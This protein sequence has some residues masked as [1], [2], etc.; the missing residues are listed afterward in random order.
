MKDTGKRGHRSKSSTLKNTFFLCNAIA[1]LCCLVVTQYGHRWSVPTLINNSWIQSTVIARGYFSL[2]YSLRF[3]EAGRGHDADKGSRVTVGASPRLHC[4]HTHSHTLLPYP[5]TT[6]PQEAGRSPSRPPF[7]GGGT[8]EPSHGQGNW[9]RN[10]Q[11]ASGTAFAWLMKR[12]GKWSLWISLLPALLSRVTT[13]GDS[14][15]PTETAKRPAG[16]QRKKKGW[17]KG[18]V[19]MEGEEA[20]MVSWILGTQVGDFCLQTSHVRK[21]CILFF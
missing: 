13:P 11:G 18:V 4:L 7:Q 19:E 12:T 14:T 1:S 8:T 17:R 16:R 20:C 10:W 15:A 9:G 3:W 5:F 21:I 2:P 6:E